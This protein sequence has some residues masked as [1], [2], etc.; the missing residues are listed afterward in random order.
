MTPREYNLTDV[1]G[2]K[3]SRQNALAL[4]H[5]AIGIGGKAPIHAIAER[6]ASKAM[7]AKRPV[8][9]AEPISWKLEPSQVQLRRAIIAK[10]GEKFCEAVASGLDTILITGLYCPEIR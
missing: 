8:S 3:A 9:A 1:L 5:L 7:R 4:H 2:A 6:I 10:L